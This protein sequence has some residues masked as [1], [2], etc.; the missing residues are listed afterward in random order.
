MWPECRS[1]GEGKG[2]GL[3]AGQSLKVLADSPRAARRTGVGYGKAGCSKPGLD[4]VPGST[5]ARAT[6]DPYQLRVSQGRLSAGQAKVDE[7]R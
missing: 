1:Q 6:A 3:Q 2:T 5:G 4:P 7:D